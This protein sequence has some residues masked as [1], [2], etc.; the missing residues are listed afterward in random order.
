[1]QFYAIVSLFLA[2]TAYAMPATAPGYDAC[3]DG[4]LF[5]NPQCCDVDLIG[6]LSAECRSPT[7]TPK[8]AKHFQEICAK[9]GQRARCCAAAE[10]L[11]F[12]VLCQ[13]PVGVAA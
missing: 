13:K 12:G 2:G 5:G 1:M 4:G 11:E 10:V 6:V 8:D 3:P 7:K 9:S